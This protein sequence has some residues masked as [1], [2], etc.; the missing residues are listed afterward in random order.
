[1]NALLIDNLSKI[2]SPSIP[3]VEGV[4]LTVPPGECLALV[5]PSGCGKTTLLRMIAGLETPS[6]G[7]IELDGRDATHQPAHQ[8]G[9]A[10]TFQRPA[11]LPHQTVRQNL[12]WGWTLQ[13]PSRLLTGWF[14]R[15]DSRA[16]ELAQVASLLALDSFLDRRVGELSGGQQQRVALG[17]C[18]LRNARLL[19]LDEPLSQLDAPLRIEMRRQIKTLLKERGLTAVHVTHDPEEALALGDRIAVMDQGRLI[20]IDEPMALRQSPGSRV[21]AEWMHQAVG[22]MTFVAGEFVRAEMDTYF[23]CAFGRWPV[24]VEVLGDLRESLF[25]CQN[26]NADSGKVHILMGIAAQDVACDSDR[27]APDDAIRLALPVLAQEATTAGDWIVAGDNR[28]R[29]VGR[30]AS[31]L[32]YGR[33]EQV[34]MIFTMADAFWFDISTGRTYHAPRT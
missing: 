9:V 15:D 26:F 33:G 2:Y 7:T 14:R 5:G 29:W 19:L 6:A 20:Q 17:R 4:T 34:T 1:M 3:A 12:C 32:H 27:P 10:M 30:L 28:G 24:S 31:H 13:N 21:V 8:R 18:L 23:E 22:G 25:E 11:L 16:E